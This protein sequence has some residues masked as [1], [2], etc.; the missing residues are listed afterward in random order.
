MN[1]CSIAIIIPVFNV[2]KYVEE[3]LI[4]IINQ[5]SSPDEVIL[6]D[7]GSTDNSYLILSKYNKYPGFRIYQTA[8]HGSAHARN[9]GRAYSKS[10][11]VYFLDADDI[12]NKDLIHDIRS[13]IKKYDN[14]DMILFSGKTF[15]ETSL[16]E[17][18]SNF[19]FSL[20]GK[21]TRE[22]GLIS[23]LTDKK[24]DLPQPGRWISKNSLWT[25]NKI[26]FPP[27]IC[28]DEAVFWPLLAFSK[29]TIILP[30]I[31]LNYR[32][33]RAGS[34]I[35]SK[36]YSKFLAV[37][38]YMINFIILFMKNNPTL[39][40]NDIFAWRY[41]LGRNGLKYISMCIKTKTSIEWHV[42]FSLIGK[43]K[44]FNYL[45]KI[46]WRIIK[47]QFKFKV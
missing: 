10:D 15:S 40:K 23:K 46:T 39:I 38:L 3:T 8:N 35:S 21:F 16:P 22:S 17:R 25:K 28:E 5:T 42:I 12:I 47:T 18:Q 20:S 31:Y 13:T 14:P 1:A 32:M 30:K 37:N 33:G 34:Q 43:M 24:E 36:A 7:D 9:F 11:Y 2:E 26:D 44:S 45:F 27:I 6:I 19:K 29:S 41:R 4:S